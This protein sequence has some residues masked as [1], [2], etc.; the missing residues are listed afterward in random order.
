MKKLHRKALAEYRAGRRDRDAW[1]SDAE[2]QF[3]A[4]I[5]ASAQ[6]LY[7]FAEDA[8]G[9]DWETALL[10]AAVRRDYFLVVQHGKPSRKRVSAGDL[11]ARDAE[12][13]GIP[14]LPRIIAK[15]EAR[16]RGEMDDALMYCCG[17]DRAFFREHDVHPADFL[18]IV[19]SAKGDADTVLKFVRRG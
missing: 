10:I 5:G 2:R 9:I 6:E 11:P 19:W 12:L 15:A 1:F 16:L 4:S 14:W 3:L 17:G 18:R 7:D 8:A 13:G